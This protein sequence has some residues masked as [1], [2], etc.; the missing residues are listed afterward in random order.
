MISRHW[1]GIAHR[2]EA[3][4][5]Q[6]YLLEV[7]FPKLAK[8]QG[9]LGASVLQRPVPEGIQFLVVTRWQTREAIRLFAGEA[10]ET[11]VVPPAVQAM[12]VS[13]DAQVEHF[14]LT[15]TFPGP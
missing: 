5:Y 13:F 14:E 12:M 15:A 7:T 11:A 2:H 4:N 10:L 8:L 9:F 1:K 3:E 6:A